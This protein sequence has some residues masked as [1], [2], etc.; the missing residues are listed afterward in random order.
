[1]LKNEEKYRSHTLQD[2][3]KYVGQR[4]STV[5]IS[6]CILFKADKAGE[7]PVMAR[8]L[9]GSTEAY[10]CCEHPRKKASSTTSKS[11]K[12]STTQCWANH[13]RNIEMQIQT[14]ETITYAHANA[15]SCLRIC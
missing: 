15:S 13:I 10:H 12:R 3:N 7:I 2:Q 6:Q 14:M 8:N 5:Q 9:M 11:T 4:F 1:M